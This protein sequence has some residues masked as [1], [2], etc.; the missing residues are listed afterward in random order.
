MKHKTKYLIYYAVFMSVVLGGSIALA[1]RLDTIVYSLAIIIGAILVPSALQGV[2]WHEL[3]LGRRYLEKGQWVKA[4]ESFRVF[5]DKLEKKPWLKHLVWLRWARFT[6]NVKA[7]ALSNLGVAELNRGNVKE[8]DQHFRKAS[9][10]DSNYPV[11]Y[12]NL[13]VIS[14]LRDNKTEAKSFLQ[15]ARNL[16]YG[17]TD[18][19]QL[20]VIAS[21]LQKKMSRETSDR[22]AG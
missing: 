6:G 12:F 21:S 13:A 1:Y 11:A 10:L 17:R 15:K 16:G 2:F 9:E 4:A 19:T 5:L 22:H 7:M 20:Q 14:M 8:A 18:Y 3:F